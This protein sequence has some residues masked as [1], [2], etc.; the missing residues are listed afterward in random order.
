MSEFDF[1]A[2]KIDRKGK[3]LVIEF[4]IQKLIANWALVE[5]VGSQQLRDWSGRTDDNIADAAPIDPKS[6]QSGTN[7]G[8]SIALFGTSKDTDITVI[9]DARQDGKEL[10]RA[11]QVVTVKAN[12]GK[13]VAGTITLELK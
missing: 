12:K 6:L 11:E 2:A 1:T 10:G 7:L 13:L 5:L 8:F 3:S 4:W 9:V